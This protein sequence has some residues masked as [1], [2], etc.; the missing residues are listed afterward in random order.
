MFSVSYLLTGN[1]GI[2]KI[3]AG[4]LWQ[5]SLSEKI[6]ILALKSW[7]IRQVDRIY[8]MVVKRHSA[9]VKVVGKLT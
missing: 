8:S 6:P 5:D 9:V 2:Q 4:V 3:A 1:Y 7:L